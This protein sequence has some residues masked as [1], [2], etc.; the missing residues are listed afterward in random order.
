[1]FYWNDACALPVFKHNAVADSY[2]SVAVLTTLCLPPCRVD[3]KDP[4]VLRL[5]ILIKLFSAR[6]SVDVQRS[7]PVCWWSQCSGDD[8]VVVFLWGR[9]SQVFKEPQAEGDVFGDWQAAGDTPDC[10]VGSE[11]LVYGIRKIFRRHQ[12]S[13]ASRRF[14]IATVHVSPLY[15]R[16]GKIQVP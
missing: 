7:P 10:L 5:N 14:A 13:K 15:S 9:A 4:K 12:V 16:T 2:Y 8:T 11:C 6:W 3:P 1:M